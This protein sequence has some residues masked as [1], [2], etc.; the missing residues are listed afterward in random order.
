MQNALQLEDD[1]TSHPLDDQLWPILK[2]QEDLAQD[3]EQQGGRLERFQKFYV[4]PFLSQESQDQCMETWNE[5][6]LDPCIIWESLHN[7]QTHLFELYV[8][9][10]VQLTQHF[11]EP[12]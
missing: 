11:S 10:L 12:E 9:E 1:Q 4:N 8:M 3:Y 5:R 6:Y 7:G 2:N